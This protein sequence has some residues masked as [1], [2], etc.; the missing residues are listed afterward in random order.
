MIV[1]DTTF[2][3]VLIVYVPVVLLNVEIICG[4]ICWAIFTVYLPT[5]PVPVENVAILVFVKTPWPDK[6]S[7]TTKAPE[8]A[9]VTFKTVDDPFIVTKVTVCEVLTV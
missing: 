2:C 4:R 5:P 3:A 9:A 8:A 1:V 6:K 7:P